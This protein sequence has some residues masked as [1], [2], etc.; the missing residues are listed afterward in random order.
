MDGERDARKARKINAMWPSEENI[1]IM[2]FKKNFSQ[3]ILYIYFV[4]GL[5]FVVE[6]YWI[7]RL[8]VI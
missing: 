4:I 2:N 7:D 1:L 5:I 6:V 3:V 8:K